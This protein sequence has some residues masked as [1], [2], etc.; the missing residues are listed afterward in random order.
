MFVLII[1]ERTAPPEYHVWT[2]IRRGKVEMASLPKPEIAKP[3]RN[4]LHCHVRNGGTGVN[5]KYSRVS[6]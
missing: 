6:Q 3:E 5:S 2:E 4:L 1:I